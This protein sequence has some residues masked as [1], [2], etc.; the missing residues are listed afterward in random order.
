MG[1]TTAFGFMP[2]GLYRDPP[3]TADRYRPWGHGL[4]LRL[5][6]PVHADPPIN[7][8]LAGHWMSWAHALAAAGGL[9]A[10]PEWTHAALD[11]VHW[12]LGRNPFNASL[13]TGVG[14]GHPVPHSRFQGTIPGGVMNGP[15]GTPEDE[16]FLD[17]DLRIDWGSTEYWNLPLAN[18]L[19]ALA[20]LVPQGI[21]ASLK[22]G[23]CAA[24]PV[25]ALPSR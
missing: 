11:Q 9:L 16:P 7:H 18:L 1:A 8:G 22:I 17:L 6:M 5:F 14:Y 12:L 13:V 10:R 19:Q 25:A 20:R 23:R 15:R 2:Y 3:R 4:A 24:R 21:P